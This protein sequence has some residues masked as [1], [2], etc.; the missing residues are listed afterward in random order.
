MHLDMQTMSAVSVT[1]TLVLGGVLLFTWARERESPLVG[2][3]GL[4]LMIQ[5]AGVALSAAASPVSS[6]AAP[7][8]RRS[9]D[10]SRLRDQ[11]E[12][13]AG[14]RPS[15]RAASSGSC[16][17][18]SGSC[19]PRSPA[20][21]NPS[22]IASPP[23]ARF[24]PS[25]ISPRRSSSPARRR[26][27]PSR[28]PA[29]TLLVVIGLSYLSWLPLNLAMPIRESQWVDASIWFPTVILLHASAP[30]RP[31]LHRDVDGQGA[32]GDWSSASRP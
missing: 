17:D 2:W 11:M 18:R 29:V 30:R 7:R 14:V 6:G 8:P 26:A 27:A 21:S 10:H 15:P 31:R 13:R 25:T 5:A 22:T 12:G 20:I 23:S 28:W 3:W 1:V 32:P 4:A 24:C 16:W 19:W 9:L